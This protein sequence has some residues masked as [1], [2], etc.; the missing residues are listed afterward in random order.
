MRSRESKSALHPRSI[1][2]PLSKLIETMRDVRKNYDKK[3][4]KNYSLM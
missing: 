4:H 3:L 2:V 1:R